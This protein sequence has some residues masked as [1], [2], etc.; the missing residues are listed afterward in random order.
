MRSILNV[1]AAFLMT[2]GAIWFL[3]GINILPGSFMTGNTVWAQRGGFLALGGLG[4][5]LLNQLF[6][7]RY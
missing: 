1:A 4:L 7:K 6:R 2:I 3:Q 5:L